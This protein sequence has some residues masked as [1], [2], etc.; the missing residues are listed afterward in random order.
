M[1][2]WCCTGQDL[3]HNKSI[4]FPSS[5]FVWGLRLAAVVWLVMQIWTQSDGNWCTTDSVL[6]RSF[7]QER[8]LGA[9]AGSAGHLGEAVLYFG[10]RRADQD[11]LYGDT[12]E[13]WGKSG[14]LTL[15]TAFSRQQARGSASSAPIANMFV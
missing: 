13:G 4:T 9:H 11:Y 15:F 3:P 6:R 5:E 12:L 2:R 10:C 8:L 14:N 1:S 7:M